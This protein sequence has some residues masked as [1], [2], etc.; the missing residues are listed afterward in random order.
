MRSTS[1]SPSHHLL[2]ISCRVSASSCCLRTSFLLLFCSRWALLT[3]C[4]L[5][6]TSSLNLSTRSSISLLS[7]VMVSSSAME[8]DTAHHC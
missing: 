8:E 2:T 7:E 4:S 3:A 6:L 5:S 1:P